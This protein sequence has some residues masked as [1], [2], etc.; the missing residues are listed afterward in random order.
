[1]V[2]TVKNVGGLT[3]QISVFALR[4]QIKLGFTSGSRV[5]E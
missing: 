3:H 4:L 1:M 5:E 2:E